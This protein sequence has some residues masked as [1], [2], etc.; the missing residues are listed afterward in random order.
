[1]ARKMVKSAIQLTN[2]DEANEALRQIGENERDIIAAENIMNEQIAAAKLAAE[3][4]TA[5]LRQN[6]GML[7]LALK[8]FATTHRA[9]MGK[10]K[11]KALVFGSISFRQSTSV[12]LPKGKDALAGIIAR[13]RSLSMLDCIVQPPAKVD[14]NALKKYSAERIIE[15]GA[16]IKTAET[17]GYDIDMTKIERK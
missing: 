3:T 14:K 15:A 11:S 9:D 5:A 17:F 1:M 8:E 10:A 7:A 16:S 6:M 4:K 13:L 12:V 2:W